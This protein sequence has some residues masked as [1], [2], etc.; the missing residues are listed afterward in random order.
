[1]E[2]MIILKVTKKQG[3]TLSL[4]RIFFKIQSSEFKVTTAKICCHRQT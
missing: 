3:Y 2:L 4:D 1:M